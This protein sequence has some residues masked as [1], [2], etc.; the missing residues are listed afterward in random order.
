MPATQTARG[1][2]RRSP[3]PN[4]TPPPV[5]TEDMAELEALGWKLFENIEDKTKPG[6]SYQMV[7]RRM[8]W[9]TDLYATAQ[10]AIDAAR[11]IQQNSKQKGVA[12]SE[13]EPDE[14][15]AKGAVAPA[16]VNTPA[17]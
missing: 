5:T 8:P 14:R 3:K 15:F 12:V 2:G 11:T 13:P 7:N 1:R 9:R 16:G 4:R 10:I 6:R 17:S